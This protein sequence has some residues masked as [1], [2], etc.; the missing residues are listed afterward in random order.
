L[1]ERGR[2]AADARVAAE[3]LRL[4]GEVAALMASLAE[5]RAVATAEAA[6]AAAAAEAA[7]QK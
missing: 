3:I 6:R 5:S 4:R 7:R 1:E 2:V